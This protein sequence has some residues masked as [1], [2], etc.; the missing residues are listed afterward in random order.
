MRQIIL[1]PVIFITMNAYAQMPGDLDAD[2]RI[3]YVD[4]FLFATAWQSPREAYPQADLAAGPT[5][6]AADAL[7]LHRRFGRVYDTTRIY[8]LKDYFA[9]APGDH[10][11]WGI[12][13]IDTPFIETAEAGPSLPDKNGI[14]RPTVHL[15]SE[16]GGIQR[17]FGVRDGVVALFGAGFPSDG[18]INTSGLTLDP[19]VDFGGEIRVGDVFESN[20]LVRLLVP[21]PPRPP[22][23]VY[24]LVTASIHYVA[25]GRPIE[26]PA[27]RFVDTLAL[28]LEVR[29]EASGTEV[30]VDNVAGRFWYA[31]GVGE[32]KRIDMTGNVYELRE[33]E[34]GG[35]TW[36]K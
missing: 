29:I 16:L 35:V 4:A 20:S 23:V 15:D 34:V 33:A 25:A 27:G 7:V 17:W 31:R 30:P 2:G 9:P 3:D 5:V 32:V 1:I 36:P 12:P 28:D 22:Q 10:W 18:D 14:P 24:A 6:D 26:V 13:G 21:N 8:D 19:E 11:V